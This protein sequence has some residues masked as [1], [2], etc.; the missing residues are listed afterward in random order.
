M[1]ISRPAPATTMDGGLS[2]ASS[3]SVSSTTS[4]DRFV[5]EASL[6][7][8]ILHSSI[9][10]H[11]GPRERRLLQTPFQARRPSNVT[12]ATAITAGSGEERAKRRLHTDFQLGLHLVVA[13]SSEGLECGCGGPDTWSATG[14]LHDARARHTATLLDNGNV[15][16]ADG[17]GPSDY[18]A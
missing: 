2:S 14:P 11:Q 4:A 17:E 6:E 8:P 16:A 12:T 13:G 10:V 15:L 7:T 3:V 5:G 9:D 1:F 18:L